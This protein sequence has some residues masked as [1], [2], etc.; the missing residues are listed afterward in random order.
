MIIA[1]NPI[2]SLHNVANLILFVIAVSVSVW[3]YAFMPEANIINQF[4]YAVLMVIGVN[5]LTAF[6]MM[7]FS[8]I[9]LID[10]DWALVALK[11]HFFL[12]ALYAALKLVAFYL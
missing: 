6:F 10:A 12:L 9:G 7:A 11:A 5:S 3:L 1:N 8:L 2:Q 4:A